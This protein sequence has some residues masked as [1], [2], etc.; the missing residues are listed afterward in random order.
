MMAAG[1][2]ISSFYPQT[3]T[4]FPLLI[5]ALTQGRPAR[6]AHRRALS[7]GSTP[8]RASRPGHP[9]SQRDECNCPTPAL[10]W[11][12]G[13]LSTSWRATKAALLP[14]PCLLNRVSPTSGDPE[15]TRAGVEPLARVTS[16]DPP[17]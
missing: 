4:P 8:G 2:R 12:P 6:C 15:M 1:A 9:E 17:P 14:G 5:T 10:Q 13:G 16:Y 7:R 11:A 3:S